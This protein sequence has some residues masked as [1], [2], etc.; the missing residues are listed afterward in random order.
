MR[1][2]TIALRA[3]IPARLRIESLSDVV[4][5]DFLQHPITPISG[6]YAANPERSG[7]PV[8]R[9]GRYLLKGCVFDVVRREAFSAV[10][11][12]KF[13]YFTCVLTIVLVC[14]VSQLLDTAHAAA[15]DPGERLHL[16]MVAP[17]ENNSGFRVW[18]SKYY[19]G[20]VLS[21]KM[22]D[23]FFRRLKEV[24]RM[25][26]SKVMGSSP[27]FWASAGYSPSD[28]VVRVNLEQFNYKKK[29][30]IGSRVYWDVALHM[31]VYNAG[32]KR[33]VY[34]T[35]VREKDERQY[36][37]YNDVL[38]AEPVYWDVFEKS[39]YWPAIRKALDEAFVQVVDGYNGYR[40]VGQIVA[41][42]ERVDGSLSV[43]K[44][45]QDR[46]YHVNIGREDSLREGDLLVVTRSSSVRTVA[47]ETPEMHF[48][49]VVGRVR[50]VFV[51]G[52][53]AVV[54]IVKES[55]DA[56]IQLGDAVS[57]PLHGKRNVPYF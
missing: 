43:P 32:S 44:K 25:Q 19:P 45:Q 40:V 15:L 50:V 28:L 16:R 7:N 54:E 38:E 18:G 56:P 39:P 9:C 27:D 53:D 41:K 20:D 48:P 29:D 11:K 46:L 23:H 31:Y 13:V 35:V 2:I 12:N 24:P 6:D 8:E 49:Q 34:E 36:V 21:E 3:N 5:S 10:C 52:Q 55:T 22:T 51:K 17:I 1:K 47:P 33:I 4:D 42:A 37:L 26:A 57:T 30:M 14:L